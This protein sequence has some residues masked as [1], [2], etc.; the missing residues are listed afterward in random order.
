MSPS[1][2]SRFFI[3]NLISLFLD[4]SSPD[5]GTIDSFDDLPSTSPRPA[6]HTVD[7]LEQPSSTCHSTRVQVTCYL[8]NYH[9][10]SALATLYEPQLFREARSDSLWQKAMDE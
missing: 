1:S 4:E 3:S 5:I 2:Y 7:S 8:N 6:N 10:Y 9:C